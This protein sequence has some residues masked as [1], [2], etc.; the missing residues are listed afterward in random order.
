[1][2]IATPDEMRRRL[3]GSQLD[4]DEEYEDLSPMTTLSIDIKDT[5]GKRYNASFVYKVPSIGEQIEIGRLKSAYLP[6]GAVADRNAQLLVEQICYL[7]VTI[8][9]NDLPAWWKPFELYDAAPV[10]ALYAE[11]IKYERRFLGVDSEVRVAPQKDQV[12]SEVDEGSDDS[13]ANAVGSAVPRA[14]KRRETL[15]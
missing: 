4:E 14:T 11:A 1:M 12:G 5:R 6:Q 7:E 9:K 8:Q 2:P 10:T 3:S 15:I 13:T